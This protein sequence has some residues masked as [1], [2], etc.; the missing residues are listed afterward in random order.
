MYLG[1]AREMTFVEYG[2]AEAERVAILSED[3][4]LSYGRLRERVDHFAHML[5]FT[6]AEPGTTVAISVENGPDAV[7]AMLATVETGAAYVFLDRN[8]PAGRNRTVVNDSGARYIVVDTGPGGDRIVEDLAGLDLGV[9]RIDRASTASIERLS[10][11][12][13][14]KVV[15]DDTAVIVYTSGSTGTPKGI[16]QRRR[17]IGAFVEWFTG[18]VGIAAGSRVLQWAQ[19]TY[20]AA[21]VEI[22]SAVHTGA[23][24]VMPPPGV[25]ADVYQILDWLRQYEVTHIQT[26]PSL[27]RALTEARIA[28]GG[29]PFEQA[30]GITIAGE[31]LRPVLLAKVREAFPRARIF[32]MYGPAESVLATYYDTAD[33]RTQSGTIPI[34]R[35]LPDHEVLLCDEDGN[36][37]APGEIG[38]VRVRS[39]FLVHGYLNRPELTRAVFLDDPQGE[40]GFRVYRTGDLARERPDG[41]LVFEGRIDNQVKIRGV[42]VELGEIEAVLLTLPNVVHAAVVPETGDDDNLRLVAYIEPGGGGE[43]SVRN[44]R[45]ALLEQ[46]PSNMVPAHFVLLDRMPMTV[47]GKIDRKNLRPL[48]AEESVAAAPDGAT[49]GDRLPDGTSRRLAAI[50]T[51]ILGNTADGQDSDFFALGG[52]SLKVPQIRSAV[53]DS[54]GVDVPVAAFYKYPELGRF[55]AYL[56]SLLEDQAVRG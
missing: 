55:A 11:R 46:L 36:P 6:G 1:E 12:P 54:F 51:K 29:G 2:P 7:A 33:D 10:N 8:Q 3:G 15:P 38:E 44:M 16:V 21:Y 30:R 34:G 35:A 19:F 32:N 45:E 43:V 18:V 41:E 53:A 4:P 48:P 28:T 20:D 25:K 14:A 5:V 13:G 31:A 27:Y 37:V 9:V 23:T 49:P 42:R 26:A 17:N 52:D 47:S 24:L 50:W 40:P 56:D 39:R 22:F